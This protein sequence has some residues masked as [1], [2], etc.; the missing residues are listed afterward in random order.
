MNQPPNPLANLHPIRLTDETP[1]LRA[2]RMNLSHL[3]RLCNKD[4]GTIAKYYRLLTPVFI[5]RG[6]D[7]RPIEGTY[8]LPKTAVALFLVE[9][10][11]N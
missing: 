5:A 6:I 11:F 7:Y 9:L 3:A 1:V 2:G 8:D 4:R 10:G